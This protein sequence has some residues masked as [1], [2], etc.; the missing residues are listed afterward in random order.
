MR[1]CLFV[2]LSVQSVS[3]GG[4]A[5]ELPAGHLGGRGLRGRASSHPAAPGPLLA[6]HGGTTARVPP[7]HTGRVKRCQKHIEKNGIFVLMLAA[8]PCLV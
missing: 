6:A 1:S 2:C 5:D 7:T 4:R 8:L 3:G